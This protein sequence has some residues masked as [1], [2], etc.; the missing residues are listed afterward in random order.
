MIEITQ[1]QAQAL[2]GFLATLR[3]AD[4]PWD[5]PG[6]VAALGRARARSDAAG[7]A[8]AAIRAAAEPTNRTPAIIGFDGNHW[9]DNPQQTTT[10]AASGKTTATGYRHPPRTT[11]ECPRHIGQY[12]ASCASCR[13]ERLAPT[14]DDL[15][16]AGTA[17]AADA[18]AALARRHQDGG[19]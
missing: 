7:L 18:R 19:R 14:D 15:E 4:A 3:P 6:I 10:A 11:E 1:D 8:I 16:P 13:S 9:R 5:T 2:A 17:S 12:A